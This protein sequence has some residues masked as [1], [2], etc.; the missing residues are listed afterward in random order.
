MIDHLH[1]NISLL[2]I[3]FR[4]FMWALIYFQN[5]Y[6]LTYRQIISFIFLKGFCHFFFLPGS[7]IKIIISIHI[8]CFLLE[9]SMLVYIYWLLLL[10]IPYLSWNK[11]E[12]LFDFNFIF[13]FENIN[14]QISF[15]LVLSWNHQ[16]NYKGIQK[17]FEMHLLFQIRC[18][19][20]FQIRAI[21]LKFFV[22]HGDYS[23]TNEMHLYMECYGLWPRW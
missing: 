16:P 17:V 3:C 2:L 10:V 22:S 12:F 14:F 15:F 6:A 1:W 4:R 21:K 18:S 7:Y 19:N 9:Q 11:D 8:N 5:I 23:K 13:K 20:G